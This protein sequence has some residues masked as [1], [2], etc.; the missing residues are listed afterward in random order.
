MKKLL[1]LLVAVILVYAAVNHKFLMAMTYLHDNDTSNDAQAVTLLTDAVN[2]DQ[3]RKSAFLLG[4]YYKTQKYNAI[5]MEASHNNY[6]KAANW[7]DEE[8]KMIVA[9]N[10]YKGKGCQRNIAKAKE[11]LTQLSI[12]G[13]EKAKE[14]LKFVIRN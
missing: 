2:N 3:D 4:Y 11:L 14:V 8:A 7:G 5:N 6:L 12:A 1:L 13:N 10:F 9:W